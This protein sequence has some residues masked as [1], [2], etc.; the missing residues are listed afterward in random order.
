MP[1]P[2]ITFIIPVYNVEKYLREC[3]DSIINQTLREIQIICINDGSTDGSTAILND[4]A[5][6]DPRIFILNLPNG[7]QSIARNTA[8]KYAEGEYI[9]FVDSD[10][11][12]DLKAAEKLYTQARQTD[13]DIVLFDFFYCNEIS[14]PYKTTQHFQ[15]SIS[16]TSFDQRVKLILDSKGMMCNKL[17]RRDFLLR[18]QIKCPEKLYGED[19]AVT[20]LSL[21]LANKI[22]ILPERLYYYRLRAVSTSHSYSRHKRQTDTIFVYAFIHEELIRLGIFEEFGEV[23][24]IR[25]LR[26]FYRH[27]RR[28]TYMT[29]KER[30]EIF[31][32]NISES[33]IKFFYKNQ[34]SFQSNEKRILSC[35][36][37]NKP[38]S[39]FDK[40]CDQLIKLTP[41]ID[42]C[43]FFFRRRITKK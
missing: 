38:L 2:K 12:I 32:S 26:V 37:K 3:L 6:C 40:I 42:S 10:D 31:R 4:Y 41:F 33:D 20:F 29:E 15:Q 22:T 7:G 23:F 8:Y 43:K 36:I 11:F 25:K 16:I 1:N 34:S 19:Q 9:F 30:M 27:F 13:A 24:S 14:I 18:N 28:A 17:Y 21:A 35:I 5:E 39:L